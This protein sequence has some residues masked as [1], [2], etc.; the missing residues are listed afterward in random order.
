M[1]SSTAKIDRWFSLLPTSTL[2]RPESG[3]ISGVEDT[4]TALAEARSLLLHLGVKK[5]RR[6]LPRF[7]RKILVNKH[8]L[9]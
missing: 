2:S 7:R 4:D 8:T 6:L 9:L 3:F 5:K 1:L